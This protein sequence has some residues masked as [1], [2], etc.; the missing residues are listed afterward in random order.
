MARSPRPAKTT[1]ATGSPRRNRPAG[2]APPGSPKD[3]GPAPFLS[4]ADVAERAYAIFLARGG[5][6]GH[7]WADWFRAEAELRQEH[8][9]RREPGIA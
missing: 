4:H 6:H 8:S 2:G 3:P 5:L 9:S 1:R 7:D